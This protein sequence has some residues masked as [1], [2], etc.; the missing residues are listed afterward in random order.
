MAKT[1]TREKFFSWRI[2]VVLFMAIKLIISLFPYHYGIFR[3][4]F[5]YLS[6]SDHLDWGYLEVPPLPAFIL[7][8]SR[9]ILGTSFFSLH[10]APALAGAAVVW[11]TAL[12]VKRLEGNLFALL[13]TLSCVTLAPMYVAHDTVFT[14]DAFDQLFWTLSLYFV[15]MLIKT[16]KKRYWLY[17]AIAAGLGILSKISILYLGLGILIAFLLT[18]ERKKLFN[19]Y[20]L[21]AG[22]ISLLIASPFLIWQIQ[23]GFPLL[24]YLKNYTEKVEKIG[25][26]E[27]MLMQAV[28]VN[29]LSAVAWILGLFYFL[30]N[31]EGRQYR[32][33]GLVYIIIAALFMLQHAKYYLLTAYYPILIAG[34]AVRLGNLLK[35]KGLRWIRPAYVSL[36]LAVGLLLMPIARPVMSP[37]AF[38]GFLN[39]LGMG[40]DVGSAEKYESSALPQQYADM[41]GW[42]EMTQKVAG[43]YHSLSDEEQQKTCI[44]AQNYGEAGA[45]HFYGGKYRIPDPISGHNVHYFWGPGDNSGEIMIAVGFDEEDKAYLEK[46]YESVVIADT[47][48]HPYGMPFENGPIFLCKGIKGNFKDLW[49]QTKNLG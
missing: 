36:V 11:I 30:F 39:A 26:V 43:V 3:D 6:M 47:H 15:L 34:G 4:E 19:R 10:I 25:P 14:Y 35:K 31:R 29:P 48:F 44:L 23:H 40:S 37:E 2:Y 13:A 20:F 42:E 12:M 32:V 5:L 24:E 33:F 16:E 18:K 38:I 21:L 49:I 28:A 1:L 9:F 41:F 8:I 7:A 27:F 46:Y 22:L 17:F 45:L